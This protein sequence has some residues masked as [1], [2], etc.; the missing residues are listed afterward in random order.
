[1]EKEF[2][3]VRNSEVKSLYDVVCVDYATENVDFMA[4][5]VDFEE[6]QKIL[7]LCDTLQTA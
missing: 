2:V 6:A 4:K 3:I 7:D 1:M 5:A